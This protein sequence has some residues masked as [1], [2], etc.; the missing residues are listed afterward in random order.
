MGIGLGIV[1][2]ILGLILVTGAI[3]LPSGLENAIDSQTLGAI[4]L[5]VGILAII[6]SLVLTRQRGRATTVVEQR[7]YDDRPPL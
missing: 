5:V 1:L 6:L 4:F 7:R 3:N 2:I